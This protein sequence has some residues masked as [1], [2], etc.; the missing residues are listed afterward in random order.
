MAMLTCQKTFCVTVLVAALP[1]TASCTSGVVP[2]PAPTIGENVG[3]GLSGAVRTVYF[4][5]HVYTDGSRFQ[6]FDPIDLNI[7]IRMHCTSERKDF[8]IINSIRVSLFKET[9]EEERSFPLDVSTFHAKGD[10]CFQ[11]IVLDSMCSGS[12]R[13]SAKNMALPLGRCV[14]QITFTFAQNSVAVLALAPL[15]VTKSAE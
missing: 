11:G 14:Y 7:S 5:A 6:Q 2:M 12:G 4:D 3:Y 8:S 9:G 1:M 15:V 10:N 13:I